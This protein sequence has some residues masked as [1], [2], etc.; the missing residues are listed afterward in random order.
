MPTALHP[1]PV[2]PR[3]P[4]FTWM[5]QKLTNR[6]GNNTLERTQIFHV[7]SKKEHKFSTNKRMQNI[8][9]YLLVY[10]HKVLQSGV[11][12][13]DCKF[14]VWH[15]HAI[16]KRCVGDH[17][18]QTHKPVQNKEK[19]TRWPNAKVVTTS[20][21]RLTDTLLFELSVKVVACLQLMPISSY[22]LRATGSNVITCTTS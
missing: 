5:Q 17:E 15:I 18:N 22:Q 9:L 19:N 6:L 12:R 3:T 2:A 20:S 14:P 8:F 10:Y 21:S 7:S 16:Q 13:C 4:H 1:G 11:L